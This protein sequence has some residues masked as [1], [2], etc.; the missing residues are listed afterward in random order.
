MQSCLSVCLSVCPQSQGNSDPRKILPQTAPDVD[1]YTARIDSGRTYKQPGPTLGLDGTLRL[2]LI[3]PASPGG[4][5][6]VDN[7]LC[8]SRYERRSVSHCIYRTSFLVEELAGGESLGSKVLTIPR[9]TATQNN[10]NFSDTNRLYEQLEGPK[11]R[12]G[13]RCVCAARLFPL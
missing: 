5:S 11:V 10:V 3:D 9:D 1:V 6:L 8:Q 13:S 7:S 4:E 12:R 2:D